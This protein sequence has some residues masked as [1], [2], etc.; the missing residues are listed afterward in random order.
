[1]F[2]D[3]GMPVTFYDDHFDLLL[4]QDFLFARKISQQATKLKARLADLYGAKDRAFAITNEGRSLYKFLTARGRVGRRVAPRF[5]E[6]ETTLGQDRALL[7]LV[8]KKWHIAKRLLTHIKAATDIPVLE[9]LF[10]E[11]ATPMPDLGGIQ[12]SLDKRMRHPRAFLR[13]L[14][15]HHRADRMLICMDPSNFDLIKDIYADSAAI[16]L[17]QI[18]CDFSDD[19]L[20]GHAQRVGL[21]G[22]RAAPDTLERLLPTIRFD[23]RFESD[24][25]RDANLPG[26]FRIRQQASPAENAVSL[27]QFLD[28]PPDQAMAIAAS[29]HLFSD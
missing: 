9:F 17:L 29:E 5:W 12:T 16:R 27:A 11:S 7:I 22:G 13:M 15:D 8:C 4:A 23:V 10:N 26:C 19:Y 2:S 1:M 18:D 20:I 28:I 3:Y 6:V 14:F 25:L 21:A 24:R